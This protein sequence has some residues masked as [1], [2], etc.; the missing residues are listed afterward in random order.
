L[1][2]AIF[3][4]AGNVWF[5][6]GSSFEDSRGKLST[7]TF[8]LAANMGIGLRFDFSFLILR[9]DIA[10][11]IYAP[12]IEDWV[13]KRFPKDLGNNRIQYN[14]GIGYPF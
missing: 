11:Q 5:A 1:E 3:A 8:R 6:K 10:Q 7:Q 14:L 2:G 4:D 12:D 13:V 9:L